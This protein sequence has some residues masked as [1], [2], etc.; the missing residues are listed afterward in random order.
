MLSLQAVDRCSAIIDDPY[1][2]GKI[3]ANHA[4]GSIYAMGGLPQTALAAVTLPYGVTAKSGADLRALMEGAN[5]VL[6]GADCA[7]AGG[8]IGDGA[9]LSLGFAVTGTVG[10]GRVLRKGIAETGDLL[11]LT[12]PLGTG[13]LLAA[14]MRGRAKA[15]WITAAVAHMLQPDRAAAEILQRHGARAVTRVTGAGLLGDLAEMLRASK[16]AAVVRLGTLRVLPGVPATLEE[17]I[18]SSRHLQ[19]LRM[20]RLIRQAESLT[21]PLYP[22]LFDPQTAGGLLAAV[23]WNAATAVIADLNAAGYG[24]AAVIG[25]ITRSD[26]APQNV[27]LRT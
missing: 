17:G 13:T 8:H 25:E 9:E 4:L 19:N 1:L 23:P 2:F 14:D 21:H 20:R 16:A 3:A 5:E 12:K 6:I 22:M 24:R 10:R 11:I 15:R 26:G 7:L 27:S 18:F